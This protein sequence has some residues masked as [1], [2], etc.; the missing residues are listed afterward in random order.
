MSGADR[1]VLVPNAIVVEHRHEL[2]FDEP[3]AV[4][5]AKALHGGRATLDVDAG[6]ETSEDV[7]DVG[8]P[9]LEISR[10]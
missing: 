8:L 7:R 5:R 1:G 9:L 2:W 3:R 10:E 6:H 4:I